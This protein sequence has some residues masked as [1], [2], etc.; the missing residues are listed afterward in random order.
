M[1]HTTISKPRLD[2]HVRIQSE[3]NDQSQDYLDADS[4]M[5]Y[6]S[7]TRTRHHV[8]ANAANAEKR[9]G[10]LPQSAESVIDFYEKRY[11]VTPVA[12]PA[13]IVYAAAQATADIL[14]AGLP[15]HM[16]TTICQR[17]YVAAGND[18]AAYKAHVA[19]EIVDYRNKRAAFNARAAA[20]L[21]RV[22]A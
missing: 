9:D 5:R 6:M 7:D 18:G 1:N 11:G 17:A 21:S 20:T 13:P 2:L 14:N 8:L 12:A 16:V 4:D 10:L 22:S 19:Q 15:G 3:Y